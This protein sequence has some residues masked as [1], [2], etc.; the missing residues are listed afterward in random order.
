MS[1]ESRLLISFESRARGI[2]AAFT[3][4]GDVFDGLDWAPNADGA[5]RIAGCVATFE[6]RHETSHDGGD[7]KIMIGRVDRVHFAP[8]A[9]LVFHGGRYGGFADE[10]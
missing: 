1:L 6:C 4:A 3:R 8:R 10:T 2:A 7:H 5:P 9:P